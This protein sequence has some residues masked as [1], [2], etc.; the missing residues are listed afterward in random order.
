MDR[1]NSTPTS[2][3]EEPLSL[4]GHPEFNK[5]VNLAFLKYIR[6]CPILVGKCPSTKSSRIGQLGYIVML[7]LMI[8]GNMRPNPGLVDTMQSLPTPCDFKNR[9]GFGLLHV[10]VRSLFPE[11]DMI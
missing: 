8:S 3:G 1:L 6:A 4:L 5:S 2:D 10:H 9:A 7:L 11:I